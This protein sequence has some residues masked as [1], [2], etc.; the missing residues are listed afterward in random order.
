M[1][2]HSRFLV[3]MLITVAMLVLPLGHGAA[4]VGEQNALKNLKNL[5]VIGKLADGGQFTGRLTIKAF[6]VDDL[7]QLAATGVLAGTATPQSG[8]ATA[9]P[10]LTF[11]ALAPLLDLRGTCT[12]LVLDFE[13]VFL[14]PL[15]QAV[16]LMPVV[17]DAQA[18]PKTAHLLHSMLCTLARLQ[19]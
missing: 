5:P 11:T 13:P 6:T 9:L 8:T 16:T 17:L 15:G 14:A 2:Q 18:S 3:F 7:G 4:T 12:T 1:V 10:P 19:G